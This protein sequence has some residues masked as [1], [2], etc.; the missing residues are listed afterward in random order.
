MDWTYPKKDLQSTLGARGRFA[1]L[2]VGKQ[3]V[4]R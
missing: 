1:A 4:E 2:S 3:R